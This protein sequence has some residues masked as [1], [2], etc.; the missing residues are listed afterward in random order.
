MYLIMISNKIGK[1]VF[2]K[3]VKNVINIRPNS[4]DGLIKKS[5]KEGAL[6]N[7]N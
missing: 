3:A 2:Y 6:M 7:E 4:S 5:Y 1:N